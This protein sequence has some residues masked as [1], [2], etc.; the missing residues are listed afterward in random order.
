MAKI[1]TDDRH[2]KNIANAIRESNGETTLYKP[3]EMEDAVRNLSSLNFKI[4]G[5][6]TQPDDPSENTIWVNTPNEIT[7]WIF[8]SEEPENP[9]PGMVWIHVGSSSSTKINV[10]QKHL[11]QVYPQGAKQYVESA[12]IDRE[13]LTY[14]NGVWQAWHEYYFNYSKQSY[15]WEKSSMRRTT[16]GNSQSAT[17]TTSYNS[18][19][20]VVIS[21]PAMSSSYLYRGGCY[22]LKNVDLTYIDTLVLEGTGGILSVMPVSGDAWGN[23]PAWG[24][25][26]VAYNAGAFDEEG[27]KNL[28]VKS[29]SGTYNIAI[30]LETW[31]T[32]EGASFTLKKLY[33]IRGGL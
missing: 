25:D 27:R 20:S 10:L 16:A 29:L 8:S 31:S 17:P 15:I 28:P 26:A 9:E 12:W 24:G 18:D 3:S 19:G 5:G 14:Q 33:G 4:V 1:V 7:N 13:A 11:I 21:I 32:S 30:G 6:T 2:Y 23:D 22:L